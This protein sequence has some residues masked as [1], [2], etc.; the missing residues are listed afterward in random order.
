MLAK[1]SSTFKT[2]ISVGGCIFNLIAS[3]VM[4]ENKEVMGFVVEWADLTQEKAI[5]EEINTVVTAV[6]KGNFEH[7]IALEGK[8]GFMLNLAKSINSLSGTVNEAVTDVAKALEALSSGDLTHRIDKQY[9]GLLGKL[10]GDAN[11]TSEQL[12]NMMSEIKVMVSD[13]SNAA[14]E[15]FQ[16]YHRSFPKN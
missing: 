6:S 11:K 7:S 3:P 14:K 8:D 12:A 5:E 10:T 4:D 1:L 15:I 16:W 2:Q 9:E 13:S